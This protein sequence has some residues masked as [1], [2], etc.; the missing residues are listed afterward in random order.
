MTKITIDESWA[1]EIFGVYI[2]YAFDMDGKGGYPKSLLPNPNIEAEVRRFTCLVVIPEFTERYDNLRRVRLKE[3][4]RYLL[5][6]AQEVKPEDEDQDPP[7]SIGSYLGGI[8]DFKPY[9]NPLKYHP[10]WFYWLIWDEMFPGESY[11]ITDPSRYQMA[12]DRR[13][14]LYDD[15]L[16]EDADYRV[17]T[18]PPPYKVVPPPDDWEVP[19]LDEVFNP[20]LFATTP[21]DLIGLTDLDVARRVKAYAKAEDYKHVLYAADEYLRTNT[22]GY[23]LV[24]EAYREN[25]NANLRT[26]ELFMAAVT[27]TFG[28]VTERALDELH[29]T[30]AEAQWNAGFNGIS[31]YLNFIYH[32]YLHESLEERPTEK[33]LRGL[34]DLLR[35]EER[36]HFPEPLA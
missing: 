7:S 1:Y 21:P 22:R 29:Y 28:W 27:E 32:S 26:I 2:K 15:M 11:E 16:P 23:P 4:F 3:T 20:E 18:D 13:L 35:Y 33:S 25:G 6:Y 12:Y 19:P 9:P 5:N 34:L 36:R 8:V 24:I 31:E 14:D 17:L 10:R 30:L